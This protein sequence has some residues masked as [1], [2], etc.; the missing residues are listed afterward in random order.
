MTAKQYQKE[1]AAW[2]KNPAHEKGTPLY[3]FVKWLDTLI[4]TF[5][6]QSPNGTLPDMEKY[7]NQYLTAGIY[8]MFPGLTYDQVRD[9]YGADMPPGMVPPPQSLSA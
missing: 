9:F 8:K 1:M 6:T 4:R 3:N 7:L 2:L 5:Q